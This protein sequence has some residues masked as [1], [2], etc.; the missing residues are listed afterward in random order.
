MRFRQAFCLA[1]YLSLVPLFA[2]AQGNQNGLANVRAAEIYAHAAATAPDLNT[3]H[4][5]LRK[6][7]DCLEGP[8]GPDYRKKAGDPCTGPG[9][10][11]QLPDG[12]INKI[13]VQ[14]AIGLLSVGVTFHDLPP[15]H[16]TALAVN[17]VL[18]EAVH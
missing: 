13:R 14:K 2:L 10:V 1:S 18:L 8:N 15:A 11:N 7:V 16:F 6:V 9:A 12:D 4:T 3:V 5:N 17:A